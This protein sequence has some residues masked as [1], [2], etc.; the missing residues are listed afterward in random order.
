MVAIRKYVKDYS[1][2]LHEHIAYIPV[3]CVVDF[4]GQFFFFFEYFWFCCWCCISPSFTANGVWKSLL[5]K[6]V[7][8]LQF[9]KG[10]ILRCT[11]SIA[12]TPIQYACTAILMA[13]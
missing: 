8:F 6:R 11:H 7:N 2:Y 5:K 9:F 1:K 3:D 13:E 12:V 10:F 4:C